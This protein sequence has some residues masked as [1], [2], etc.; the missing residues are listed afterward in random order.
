MMFQELIRVLGFSTPLIYA[1]AV[2]VFFNSLDKQSSARAKRALSGH[3]QAPN[4]D[5]DA[6]AAVTVELFDTLYGRRLLSMN[7]FLRSLLFTTIVTA[8]FVY[9]TSPGFFISPPLPDSSDTDKVTITIKS[10]SDA[11][12]HLTL[13]AITNILSD[14]ISLFLVRWCIVYTRRKLFVSL[15]AGP[16]LG[17]MVILSFFFVRDLSLVAL[18]VPNVELGVNYKLHS[19]G[20]FELTPVSISRYFIIPA[21]AVHLW[22]PF[23]ALCILVIRAVGAFLWTARKLQWFLKRGEQHPLQAIGY[24]A[25]L[26]T[27]VATV[28]IRELTQHFD[29]QIFV[30]AVAT[31]GVFHFLDKRASAQATRAIASYFNSLAVKR[32]ALVSTAIELFDK[33][34]GPSLWSVMSFGRSIVITTCLTL[35]FFYLSGAEQL[36]KFPADFRPRVGETVAL[37]FIEFSVFARPFLIGLYTNIISDYISLFIVRRWLAHTDR[38]PLLTLFMGAFVGAAAIVLLYFVRDYWLGRMGYEGVQVVYHFMEVPSEERHNKLMSISWYFLIPAV[39]VHLWLILLALGIV[40]IRFINIFAWSVSGMQWFLKR[41]HDH[42]LQAI[43]YIA[44]V[45]MFLATV[46]FHVVF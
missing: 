38:Y 15:L 45:L 12:S 44:A 34:Y 29:A 23:L 2:Y 4:Y 22:L 5:K 19:D 27:F 30:Y 35:G 31:Y 32:I 8:V 43:G 9:E 17:A 6:I 36:V 25:A 1:I 16:L 18:N 7:S 46:V 33:L 10:L 26:T 21:L 39:A 37:T 20:T 13:G 14:Y 41:G 24:V 28:I 11:K 40:V 42:P 3:L